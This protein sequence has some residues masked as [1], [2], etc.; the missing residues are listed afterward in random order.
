MD[1]TTD[2]EMDDW[3]V[4]AAST[5]EYTSIFHVYFFIRLFVIN[6]IITKHLQ[7]IHSSSHNHI[8]IVNP[9]T[10]KSLVLMLKDEQ[11]HETAYNILSQLAQNG[12]KNIHGKMLQ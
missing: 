1:S 9:E 6:R 5:N 2:K 8:T 3:K 12:I 10:L 11:I 7:N 4:T